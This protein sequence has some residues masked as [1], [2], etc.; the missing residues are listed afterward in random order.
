MPRFAANLTMMFHEVPFLERFERA[1]AAGFTAVE[2]LFPYAFEPAAIRRMLDEAALQCV[3]FNTPPGDWD[4][5][6][7]GLAALPGRE[8]EF[9][10]ALQRALEYAGELDCPRIHVMAGVVPEGAD[11]EACTRTFVENLKW[12][13]EKAAPLGVTL[14]VEPINTRDIPGY[15]LNT[16]EQAREILERVGADNVR[17]QFDFYHC[18]MMQGDLTRRFTEALPLVA[19][20]QIANVPGR[21]E[22]DFGEIDYRWIFAKLDELG[23]T[24]WVGCEYRPRGET[25][26]GLG[27]FAPWREGR[28]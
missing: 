28:G 22:P 12:A 8:Q 3:L 14:T 21:H 16:Q 18:Q 17:L 9:R 25:E 24:G 6:E 19:H 13:A 7:R 23:Y 10:A 2:F 4:R 11:R 27:W 5:G 20:V 26:A 1:R 15:F